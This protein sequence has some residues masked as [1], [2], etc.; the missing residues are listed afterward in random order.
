M[1]EVLISTSSTLVNQKMLDIIVT[2]T[3]RLRHLV[4]LRKQF[5]SLI[6]LMLLTPTTHS[7]FQQLI[8]VLMAVADYTT[9]VYATG[10]PGTAG[11]YTRIYTDYN[12]PTTLYYYCTNHWYGRWWLITTEV[13]SVLKFSTTEEAH[14]FADK[15]NF[16]FVNTVSPKIFDIPDPTVD[17]TDAIPTVN[18]IDNFT[19]KSS[20]ISLKLIHIMLNQL[21]H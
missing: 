18:E 21:I 9:Y 2:S 6:S 14:G 15:T 8:M 3:F 13:R 7:D 17:A 10:T 1:L 5:I 19:N 11:A 20:Q 4:L 16:Y 12:T